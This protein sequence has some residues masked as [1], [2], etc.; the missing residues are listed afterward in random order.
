[1]ALTAL[2][3]SKKPLHI[4]TFDI[5]YNQSLMVIS[6]QPVEWAEYRPHD[7]KTRHGL[8]LDI[9]VNLIP[10]MT[11]ALVNLARQISRRT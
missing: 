11:T 9:P 4:G 2:P 1:M 6:V 3:T 8:T 5:W 7:P 10:K